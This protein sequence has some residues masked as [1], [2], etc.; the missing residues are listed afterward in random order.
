M[1]EGPRTKVRMP[2]QWFILSVFALTAVGLVM[3]YS[4]T[5][6]LPVAKTGGL[7]SV[8]VTLKQFVYLKKHLLTLLIALTAMAGFYRIGLGKLNRLC[9][10]LLGLS[11]V[12]L[13]AVFIPGIG[14][15]IN[16]AR[17]WLRL[18]PS[19]FQPSELVKFAMIVYLA[20]YL[21][22]N[23]NRLYDLRTFLKPVGVMFLFQAVMIL[24]PDFGGAFT[25][26]VITI[27]MLFMAGI[28]LKFLLGLCF[29]AT[30]VV[31]YLLMTP[32]RMKRILAFLNPWEDPYNSGFQLIQSL[33]AL[34][35][36]GLKGVGLGESMQKLN[37]LPEGN[38][39]F[40]FSLLGEELGLLGAGFTLFMFLLLFLRGMKIAERAKSPFAYYLSSGLVLMIALQ[41]LIN[42][43][44]V[45]GLLPT[46][47]L[48]LP[49]ISYG[50]SSLLI[51]FI[52]VG[53]LLRISS[54][55]EEITSV[56]T[57]E[58]IIRKRVRFRRRKLRRK[59]R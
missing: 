48:P 40:I 16:G 22:E 46:K 23:E 5:A 53:V 14:V 10:V 12:L 36:G 32:Y 47:G 44:V 28:P 33:V 18:W 34:G 9:Y 45:T 27:A 20:R 54:T 26:G 13:V 25:L 6:V 11:F 37:Y 58:D 35:S 29:S 3:V 49:F 42:I 19:T 30:P 31:I 50:G 51:N 8:K 55:D 38:T 43:A 52:S 7:D 59:L 39:D 56:V 2:D 21:S 24:Q 1:N 57:K 4:S 15:K 41:A 17:R